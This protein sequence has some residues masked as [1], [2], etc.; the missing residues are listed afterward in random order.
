MFGVITWICRLAIAVPLA[1]AQPAQEPPLT[2]PPPPMPETSERGR[3]VVDADEPAPIQNLPLKELPW[4]PPNRER[5]ELPEEGQ[6]FIRSIALLLLPTEFDDEDGWGDEKR[7]Q[8]GLNV[9]FEDGQLETSRRWKN[10]NHGTWLRGSGKLVDPDK[11]FNIKVTQLPDP[12]D[13]TKRYD[14]VVS[15]RLNVTGQHQQWNLGVMLWSISADA[16]ADLT[17]RTTVDTTAGIV[18]TDKGSM[19]RFQ[20]T[21]KTASVH[22]DHF[23]LNRVS[24]VKGTI[25]RQYGE[26]VEEL[27]EL[28]IKKENKSL[29]AKINKAIAKKQDDLQIPVDFGGWFNA[30]VPKMKSEKDEAIGDKDATSTPVPSPPG[31]PDLT[32]PIPDDSSSE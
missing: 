24:H 31:L 28:R 8:S 25:A 16:M 15:A 4:Q 1:Y 21:V 12:Q 10:V 7:I 5:K 23:R 17:F 11:F 9:G 27:L 22:L 3:A 29:A 2:V 18:A 19:L 32:I 14:I 30:A 20:P 26:V 6:Q 13:G